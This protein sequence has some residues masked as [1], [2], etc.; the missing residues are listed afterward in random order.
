[1]GGE[2]GDFMTVNRISRIPTL[3]YMEMG[4]HRLKNPHRGNLRGGFSVLKIN[5]KDTHS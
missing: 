3:P 5:K 1:M 2:D 4:F